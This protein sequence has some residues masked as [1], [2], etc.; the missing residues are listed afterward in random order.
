MKQRL[1]IKK[2]IKRPGALTRKA[3]RRGMSV[4][5]MIRN[6]PKNIDTRTKR[7]INFAKLLRKLAK[8]RKRR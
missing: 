7:Q 1:D 4:G 3:K 6:P 8:R 5:E 2:A